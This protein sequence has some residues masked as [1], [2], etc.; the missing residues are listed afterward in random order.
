MARQV[1][2]P[3]RLIADLRGVGLTLPARFERANAEGAA[4]GRARP[5]LH[6]CSGDARPFSEQKGRAVDRSTLEPGPQC[7]QAKMAS[8]AYDNEI[9]Y[10][11]PVI[12]MITTGV[13]RGPAYATVEWPR[14]TTKETRTTQAD[15]RKQ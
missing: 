10:V 4:W 11:K 12:Q 2:V 9:K 3:V 13:F 5:R 14:E 8:I 7:N 1:T 15:Q 6:G